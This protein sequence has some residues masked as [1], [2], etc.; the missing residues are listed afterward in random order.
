M[1]GDRRI[2][3]P[4]LITTMEPIFPK[5]GTQPARM[6]KVLLDA[7]GGWIN[8]QYFVREMYLT[9]AGFVIHTLENKYHWPIEH[10]DFTDEWGFKSYRITIKKERNIVKI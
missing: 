8:K 5:E 9:Q 10:S 1:V 7:E 4:P 6:L 3:I 2:K